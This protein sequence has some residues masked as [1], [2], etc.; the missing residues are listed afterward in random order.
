M[1]EPLAYLLTWTTYGSWLPGDKR[2][3]VDGMHNVYGEEFA[4]ADA[5]RRA[6][7]AAKLS[8]PPFRLNHAAR[9][10]VQKAIIEHCAFRQWDLVSMNVRSNHVHVVV[11]SDVSP[12]ATASKL[13]ARAT[14]LPRE[15]SVVPI[16]RP[17]W[18][19]RGS[20]RYLRNEVA[21]QAAIR[22][23]QES[24]GPDLD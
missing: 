15:G 6:A 3:S 12:A 19:E 11:R 21:V 22:Y 1:S 17:V 5:K 14:R 18:T 7:N 23:V 10:M 16:D 24:Q 8:R 13:K 2:G 20:G 4:P 9:V